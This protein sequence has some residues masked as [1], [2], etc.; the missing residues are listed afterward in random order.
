MIAYFIGKGSRTRGALT[1]KLNVPGCGQY[2]AVPTKL[3]T[4]RPAGTEGTPMP[5]TSLSSNPP[6]LFNVEFDV[7][8]MYQI[9][10]DTSEYLDNMR[11]INAA[12]SAHIKSVKPVPN[13]MQR[14]SDPKYG[15]C[16]DP[17]SQ[18]KYPDYPQCTN[19]PENWGQFVCE[20]EGPRMESI[21]ELAAKDP[22][23]YDTYF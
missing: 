19:K 5:R 6:L 9:K 11:I 13:Q 14:G 12:R 17:N 2:D 8:E 4:P 21:Y 23:S 15:W 18:N 20:P 16:S 7:S 10:N 1:M 22:W 3:T